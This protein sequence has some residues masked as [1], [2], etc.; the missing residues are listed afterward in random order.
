MSGHHGAPDPS[1]LAQ[2][3]PNKGR[4]L[5]FD[6]VQ[7]SCVGNSKPFVGKRAV[8]WVFEC[9]RV[10]ERAV[11]PVRGGMFSWVVHTVLSA[12]ILYTRNEIL[13]VVLLPVV[14]GT[15]VS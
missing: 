6:K 5:C 12:V 14:V 3:F 4:R 10:F 8:C 2:S 9:G 7:G 11:Q 1:D 15:K 13:L